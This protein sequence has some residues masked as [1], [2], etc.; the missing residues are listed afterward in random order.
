MRKLKVILPIVVGLAV[1]IFGG[2]ALAAGPL[3]NGNTPG[4]YD[5]GYYC[6]GPGWGWGGTNLDAV[7]K[8]LGLTTEEIQTL[9]QQGQSLVQIAATKNVTEDTLVNAIIAQGKEILQQQVTAG[10]LVQAQADLMLK[11]MEQAVRQMV[12][13]TTTGPGTGWGGGMMGGR[14]MMGGWGTGSGTGPG[15]GRGGMMGRWF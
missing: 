14:G 10:N 9:R 13:S 5:A 3:N 2:A 11:N 12:N 1:L 4:T 6:G 7:S 15:A 8:L